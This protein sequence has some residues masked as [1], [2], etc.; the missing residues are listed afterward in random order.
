MRGG[1]INGEP[2]FEDMVCAT[3]FMVLAEGKGIA[4]VWRVQALEVSAELET[5]TPSGRVWDEDKYL[6]VDQCG[7]SPTGRGKGLKIP[8]GLGSSPRGRT[9]PTT[10][11]EGKHG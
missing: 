3:C 7:S 9:T 2:L 11:G 8:T 5:V 4:S 10:S 1:S 6:W